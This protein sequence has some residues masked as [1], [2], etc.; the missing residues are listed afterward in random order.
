MQ[1]FLFILY[2]LSDSLPDQ[3]C[4]SVCLLS[5]PHHALINTFLIQTNTLGL[6]KSKKIQRKICLTAAHVPELSALVIYQTN[7]ESGN[8]L[9]VMM[10]SGTDRFGALS[11]GKD[12]RDRC[13][14]PSLWARTLA[15]KCASF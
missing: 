9:T 8:S 2:I 11:E 7:T 1:H 14:S 3:G 4:F 6:S 15:G 10:S 12:G 13:R 5:N